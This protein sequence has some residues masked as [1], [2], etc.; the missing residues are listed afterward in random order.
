M[1]HGCTKDFWSGL[2][3]IGTCSGTHEIFVK[4][5]PA[6]TKT[7]RPAPTPM[8]TYVLICVQH[9]IG[10]SYWLNLRILASLILRDVALN[11]ALKIYT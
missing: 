9:V 8:C 1:Y 11:I 6:K 3:V 7:A 2:P 10:S 5:G 4:S